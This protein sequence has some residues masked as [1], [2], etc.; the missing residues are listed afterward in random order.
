MTETATGL[1]LRTR[2]LTETSLIVHW[3]T[4]DFGRVATVAKGAR[5]PKSPFRG[6]L[7]LFYLADFSFS[8]G[9]AELHL[10]REV[11]L[12]HTH[13]L[14]R[15]ELSALQQAAYCANLLEQ[16]TEIET[17]LPAA[18]GLMTS[19]LAY[20]S[21]YLPGSQAILAFELKLLNELGLRP[22]LE[23]SKINVGTRRLASALIESD[24]KVLPRIRSSE[25]QNREL[26]QFLHG[27]LVFHLGRTPKGRDAALDSGRA[28]ARP[29]EA[30]IAG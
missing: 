12:R 13:S 19:L 4:A 24:W 6:K 11:N 15:R 9:R 1:I 2:P 25:A 28:P 30:G 29:A 8:R 20:L 18:F 16:T 3:L 22:D 23:E 27:F 14:L 5:R 17:P 10:L 21:A 26:R 7:D